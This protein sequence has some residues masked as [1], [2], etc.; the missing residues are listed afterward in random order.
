[1]LNIFFTI[2]NVVCKK[3]RKKKEKTRIDNYRNSLVDYIRKK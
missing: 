1:M 2:K 3:E